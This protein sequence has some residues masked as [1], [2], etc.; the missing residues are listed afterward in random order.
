MRAMM[1][2]TPALRPFLPSD[3]AM[4][5]RIFRS[6]IEEIAVEDYS[7][8]QIEAWVST[9][10]DAAFAARLSG[11]LTLVATLGGT[12]AGFASLASDNQRI[13]MLYVAPGVARR[14]LATMLVTA[15]E[16]LAR[17]RGSAGL[18]VDASD[19]ARPLFEKLGFDSQSRNTVPVGDEW[20]GH[21]RMSK[22]LK[23]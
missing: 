7:P 22:P 3:A 12:P 4:L 19:T 14:G 6:S 17:A 21:T 1:T 15:L 20:L 10:D 8:G 9:A 13:D 23:A 11:A 16:A 18:T 2:M 5:A